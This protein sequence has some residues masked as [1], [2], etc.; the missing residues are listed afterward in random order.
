MIDLSRLQ[1]RVVVMDEAGNQYNIK[2]FIQNLGWEE[3]ENEISVRSS[4]TVR[5]DVTS[6]GQ[7]SGLIKPG[8][9]VGI[10][11][12]D[13]A[14][15]DEEV[16]RGY[17]ETW[18][19]VE[20][21]GGNDLKCTCYDELY[22]LQKSQDNRYLPSGT[23]TKSAVQGI[24]SD[25]EIPQGDYKG[26]DVS[27]GKT[28][29]NNQYLSDMILELLDEAAKKGADRCLV[30]ASKGYTSVIPWGGNETVYVFRED[31]SQSISQ[32]VSTADLITRVK[33][34]GQ[35]DH[36]GRQSV[37][38][39]VNGETRYGIRQRIYTRGSDETLSDANLAAQEILSQEGKIKK[40]MIV[41]GPDI[42]FIRKGDLV[43]L[44]TDSVKAYYYVKSIQHNA[45]TYS[46]TMELE[47]MEPKQTDNSSGG[48][49]QEKKEHQVGDM[50]DF[51]GNVHYVSSYPD[52]KGYNA[53][54]GKAKITKKD[55][56]GKA[57][58]WHLIHED[59]GSNVYGW[60]DDGTFD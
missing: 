22:K 32:S 56:S 37:E 35:A 33:V 57:H 4:F 47:Y 30:R 46:M 3:N 59:S 48:D 14:S 31:N 24:L 2:D 55:G 28:K 17:V 38:A 20:K 18:N 41:Q 58:P 23:G 44:M 39:T 43:Y 13:D 11:A 29:L 1:Y 19:Q 10:F 26:P 50:V 53:R 12:T 7:I 8:C 54:P 34:V 45:E 51:H 52:A 49:S 60:V 5:N 36:E 25:W 42:P 27:H 6:K 9:L 40:E 16:A 15:F 21:S